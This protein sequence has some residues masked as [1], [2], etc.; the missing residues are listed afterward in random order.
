MAA[1]HYGRGSTRLMFLHDPL[2][3]QPP[4]GLKLGKGST[5]L[6]QMIPSRNFDTPGP[7]NGMMIGTIAGKSIQ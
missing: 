1:G 3:V 7:H 6:A 5:S 4:D 2:F